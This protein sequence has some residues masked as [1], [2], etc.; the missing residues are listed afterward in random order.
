MG[1]IRYE[2]LVPGHDAGA[3]DPPPLELMELRRVTPGPGWLYP[4]MSALSRTEGGSSDPGGIFF[5]FFFFS[6][7]VECKVRRV[8]AWPWADECVDQ[9]PPA[10]GMT[11]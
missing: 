1:C 6:S 8:T 9:R 11:V 2:R 3:S 10:G 7:L 5:F 4:K